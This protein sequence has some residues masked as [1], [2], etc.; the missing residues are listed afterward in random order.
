MKPGW[1]LLAAT[2]L[3]TSPGRANTYTHYANLW[4]GVHGCTQ[5]AIE[6]ALQ[7]GLQRFEIE[8]AQIDI[9]SDRILSDSPECTFLYCY[10]HGASQKNQW[11][12][13]H[14]GLPG[15]R[16]FVTDC[17]ATVAA[18][19]AQKLLMK[20]AGLDTSS[21]NFAYGADESA[22]Y[23]FV[24]G[25]GVAAYLAPQLPWNA[26]VY[27][28]YC[29]SSFTREDWGI[30]ADAMSEDKAMVVTEIS[31][32]PETN[33]SNLSDIIHDM[34]CGAFPGTGHQLDDALRS[35]VE[36]M[37]IG[38]WQK[39]Q[40]V[41]NYDCWKWKGRLIH[42]GCVGDEIC[43]VYYDEDPGSEYFVVAGADT[44]HAAPGCEAEG[45]GRICCH[46]FPVAYRPGLAVVEVDAYGVETW[47]DDLQ[48]V[49][50]ARW[51][52]WRQF[53][54]WT[55]PD[56]LDHVRR[57]R[58]ERLPVEREQED[59]GG[60]SGPAAE[61]VRLAF[62]RWRASATVTTRERI[63]PSVGRVTE[64]VYGVSAHENCEDC[65]DYL[66]LAD[67]GGLWHMAAEWGAGQ[68]YDVHPEW[69]IRV[70]R[71][72]GNSRWAPREILR[73]V[74]DANAL[75]NAQHGT[76]YPVYPTPEMM[77]IGSYDV[78]NLPAVVDT[79]H[80]CIQDSCHTL[81]IYTYLDSPNGPPHGPIAW[82][83]AD[84]ATQA[85]YFL[86][87][88]WQM[89]FGEDVLASGRFLGFCS[90]SVSG[91][92]GTAPVD[93]LILIRQRYLDAGMEGGPILRESDYA[94][95]IERKNAGVSWSE[96]GFRDGWIGGYNVS[97][98]RWT[99]FWPGHSDLPDLL[100]RDQV[101]NIFAIDCETNADWWY[102]PYEMNL[103]E[104]AWRQTNTRLAVIVGNLSSAY[105]EK[106]ERFQSEF[107]RRYFDL[108]GVSFPMLV[109]LTRMATWDEYPEYTGMVSC[110]GHVVPWRGSSAGVGVEAHSGQA[111]R[112]RFYP[113]SD[114]A[115]TR[116]CLRTEDPAEVGIEIYDVLG[117]HVRTLGPFHCPAGAELLE[118][119]WR[120]RDDDGR[121]VPAG[122]YFATATAAYTTGRP[123]VRWRT[124]LLVVR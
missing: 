35:G 94:S 3:M 62:E 97:S 63:L 36:E 106:H 83:N 38:G 4:E 64:W 61:S 112:G 124:S 111:P 93:S 103:M 18:R 101:V 67:D 11:Y 50:G 85:I 15:A 80:D 72:N 95:A 117:R 122:L 39:A 108:E 68:V 121:T 118:F 21:V 51:A 16:G 23:I 42:A 116:L 28:G 81:E 25:E 99:G 1:I 91:G 86:M 58:S 69:R 109:W 102:D 100:V 65:A 120:Q 52:W 75:S 13:T 12:K 33:C 71:Y 7:T 74:R 22:A 98:T 114:G 24:R 32:S 96:E 56:Y 119:T 87:N 30:P 60:S 47:T 110:G 79:C 31:F 78:L 44:L 107:A 37:S 41:D 29:N 59:Q 82:V 2:V 115:T 34:G 27:G 8:N 113:V 92:R 123:P 40:W 88:G 5:Q 66:V 48:R 55:M 46:R 19:D 54:G 14:G 105:G 53:D 6:E 20:E 26:F 49:D 76:D 89:N 9:H 104:L 70:I 57:L 43:I 84:T 90:D 77:L 73:Q 45:P 17:F 10:Q